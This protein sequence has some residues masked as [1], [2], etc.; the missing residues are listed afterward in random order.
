MSHRG[1]DC[2]DDPATNLQTL[3]RALDWLL[4][5]ADCSALRFQRDCSWTPRALIHAAILW[6]WSDETA[7]TRRFSLARKVVAELAGLPRPPAATYQAFL[8]MLRRWTAASSAALSG[9]FR[10][11]ME[12]D[13][14]GRF[15]AHGFVIFGVDGSRLALPRTVS[16]ERRFSPAAARGPG[17]EKSRSRARRRASAGRPA[18][19]K[20]VN[21]PQLWLTVMFHVGAGLPWDWRTGPSDSGEREHMAAMVGGLPAD[22]LIT[23]D[24]GFAGYAYWKAIL[25]GGRHFL[26]RVGSNVRLLRGLGHARAGDGLVYL[27]PDREAKK[28]RPPL[29]L[30]LVVAAGG[31]SPVY[32]VTSVG[33]DRLTDRQVVEVYAARWGV[34]LFYRHF[35]QTF[36]RGKLR[37]GV[38][39]HVELEATWSLV[40][41][42][43]MCLHAQVEQAG[44][45]VPPGR[46]SVAG[47][48]LAHR[49][50]LREYKGRPDPGESLRELLHG[51]V[52]DG[53]RR[54]DKASRDYP[55]KKTRQP[56]MV[57]RILE[58]TTGQ[59][60]RLKSLK[61]P[62]MLGLTA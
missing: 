6:A 17:S 27:W 30:R 55:R 61:E 59:I 62:A 11:R 35:K 3:G 58:A 42:W 12:A 25:D 28:G 41:L 60:Q 31:R 19:S 43:A 40:G 1:T 37:S 36:G 32:V 14:P 29:V 33:A 48:L 2:P 50:T 56:D 38:A 15:R 44:R 18:D 24:A 54:G 21:C 10:R 34:E 57:P 39:G 4:A 23:A 52:I 22:A 53:Y 47:V 13:L 45:G 16:N 9:A 51:A 5:T 46:M 8:K 49:R 20:A 7:L 26:I